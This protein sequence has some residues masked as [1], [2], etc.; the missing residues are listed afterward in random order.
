M[1]ESQS[2][3]PTSADCK[4][5][6]MHKLWH[7]ITSLRNCII[8]CL[9]QTDS[10]LIGHKQSMWGKVF[11]VKFFQVS[12]YQRA[13]SQN[14]DMPCDNSCDKVYLEAFKSFLPCSTWMFG[15]FNIAGKCRAKERAR[16]PISGQAL[17]WLHNI[18]CIR[19]VAQDQQVNYELVGS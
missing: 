15:K 8:S 14:V 18:C 11:P 17:I 9:D 7:K 16:K 6:I 4:G 3:K 10:I 1:V 19:S 5:Y 2:L 13:W 12:K